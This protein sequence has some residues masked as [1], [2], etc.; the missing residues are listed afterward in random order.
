V[1]STVKPGRELNA[2]LDGTVALASLA[3]TSLDDMSQ[4]LQG[5]ATS[6]DLTG[7]ELYMLQT[8]GVNALSIL[9]DAYG[10]TQ[11]EA[12]RMVKEGKISFND[13]MSAVNKT[14]GDA[15]VIMG[16]S[17]RSMWENFNA[18]LGRAGEKI[19]GPLLEGFRTV[20][21]ALTAVVDSLGEQVGQAMEGIGKRLEPVFDSLAKWLDNLAS[22]GA[23]DGIIGMFEKFKG[24]AILLASA[25]IGPLLQQIPVIGR[26]FSGLTGPVGLVIG[27]FI[28]M[29][30][31]SEILR[32][33]VTDAFDK[34]VNAISG[35]GSTFETISGMISTLA[36]V[37]GDS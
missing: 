16:T 19:V 15:A 30:T 12:E 13:F 28:Q 5:A 32:D 31:E 17:I 36:K 25:G 9:A 14:T 37:M 18:A 21:P 2:A 20:A 6:G 34:I 8:R 26:V 10:V 24:V 27:L 23:L 33:A 3:G 29:W 35:S 1:S 4:A 11:S 7:K 22:S